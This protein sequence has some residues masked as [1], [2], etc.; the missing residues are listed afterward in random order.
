MLRYR[1]SWGSYISQTGS[2][3]V[4]TKSRFLKNTKNGCTPDN[5]ITSSQEQGPGFLY[6]AEA[7]GST[8]AAETESEASR[9]WLT[10]PKESSCLPGHSRNVTAWGVS[11]SPWRSCSQA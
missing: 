6:S 3:I 5:N 10:R 8:E 7:D 2:H 4:S 11:M 1:Q 9:S